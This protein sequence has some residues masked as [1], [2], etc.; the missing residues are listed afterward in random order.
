M[1]KKIFIAIFFIMICLPSL[2]MFFYKTDISAEKREVQ[3]FPKVKENGKVNMDFF[4]QLSDYFSD[5]FAFR[6]QLIETD[7]VIK[8][9]VFKESG[10]SEV[11][12]G[13]KGYLF[14][15]ETLN[16]YLGQNVLSGRQ[17]YACGRVLSLLQEHV[18]NN[19]GKFLFV[20]APNKNSLY[21]EFM[22]GRF[23]KI[24]DKNNYYY[25]KKQL[26]EQ[27]I[28][29]VDLKGKFLKSGKKVY[30]KLDSHWNNEGATMACDF[31]LNNLGKKHYNYSD[32][33]YSV[34]KDF[35]GDLYEMLFPKGS[36]KDYNV[37]YDKKHTYE[38]TSHF[39]KVTDISMATENKEKKGSIVMY[40]DSFG[41]ALIP[42]VADEYG[43]GYFTKAVPYDM[44]LQSENNA[45]AV[46]IE[47]VERHIPSLIE[48]APYM[49]A[50][51]RI[52]NGEVV[53]KENSGT[54]NIGDMEDYLPISGQVDQK[55]IDDNGKILIRLKS[56]NKQY[57]F[58]AFPAPINSKIKN[59]GY[60][61]G[62]YLDTSLIDGGTYDI[63]V[64]TTKNNQYYSSGVKTQ[65]ELEE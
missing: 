47:L 59:K 26:K 64:I 7:A 22:P 2:G 25:L 62:M 49:V 32:E 61:Y 14:F 54:V 4:N 63:D 52:L 40:R 55:Y 24:S 60:N 35:S 65:L 15:S 20:V 27:K 51:T 10:N 37:K 6:Q 12:V 3:T 31:I 18:E 1:K 9:N 41:N 5:N 42:F 21:S 8:K 30:H 38:V 53:E 13:N 29:T 43:S 16:D 39:K 11:I 58:E 33:K 48:E 17:I 45:E 23:V 36:E 46:V 44:N 56:K 19:N 28:N 50:P 34:K 57:V